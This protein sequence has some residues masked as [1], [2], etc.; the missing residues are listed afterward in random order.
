[1]TR[2]RL[3]V[4]GINWIGRKHA[5]VIRTY[6]LCDLVGVCDV[7]ASLASF[8]QE[9]GVPFHTDLNTLLAQTKPD[10]A[11]ISVAN[12]SHGDVAECCARHGVHSLVEKPVADTLAEAQRIIDAVDKSDTRVLVGHHRRHSPLI[13]EA[14]EVV[15]GGMLGK[16]IGVSMLWTLLKPNDY[17][18]VGWRCQRPGGGPAFINL[19]HEL[20]CLRFICGEIRRVYAEASSD[21]RGLTV[22]DTVSITLSFESG[23]VGSILASDATPA[24]WSYE[25]TTGENPHYFHVA[26]NCYHF[27]GTAGSLGFPRLELWRY[28]DDGRGWQHPLEKSKRVVC[29]ADPIAIQLRHFC[30]VIRNE[31]EPLVDARDGARSL[32]VALA[33]I[34]SIQTRSPVDVAAVK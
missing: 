8:G 15:A 6:D 21:A 9:C 27:L 7:D 16:L 3:I 1:M 29:E 18:D 33:V 2:S 26:E 17:F 28:P 4:V 32:A 24:P 10:G 25:A 19:I 20:D 14:R 22:E 13:Q 5:D 11:I 12:G 23:A 30:H 34:E 31:R